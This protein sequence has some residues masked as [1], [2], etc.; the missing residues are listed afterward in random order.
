MRKEILILGLGNVLMGDEGIGIKAVE[1]LQE[2]DLPEEVDLLD[3]GTGGF[4]LLSLFQTYRH[5]IIIDASIGG[6]EA[7][8]IRILK[9]RYASDFPRSLT[10]HDIGLKDLLQSAELLEDLPDIRLI[11]INIADINNVGIGISAKLEK[12]LPDIYRQVRV[13]LHQ[14]RHQ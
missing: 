9:P 12:R 10:S 11:A 7:G 2:K 6:E 14:I 3:G 1:Y 13:I 8:E 5:I 4:Q